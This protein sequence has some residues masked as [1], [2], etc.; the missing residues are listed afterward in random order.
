TAAR[1]SI[2][3]STSILTSTTTAMRRSAP[4]PSVPEKSVPK[5]RVESTGAGSRTGTASDITQPR[6]PNQT[7]TSASTIPRP[8][9]P[10]NT[11]LNAGGATVSSTQPPFTRLAGMAGSSQADTSRSKLVWPPPTQEGV[12]K[13]RLVGSSGVEERGQTLARTS[14]ESP[15][16]ARPVGTTS[17]RRSI[18]RPPLRWR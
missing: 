2:S 17:S 15:N 11:N 8:E 1:T 7:A 9:I 16:V 13:R 6:R 14:K 4:A 5:Q 10:K 18:T 3:P 12:T